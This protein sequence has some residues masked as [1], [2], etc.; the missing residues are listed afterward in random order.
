[1][2]ENI[3]EMLKKAFKNALAEAQKNET[4]DFKNIERLYHAQCS[5][6]W[7]KHLSDVLLK[8]SIQQ[9]IKKQ[10]LAFYKGNAENRQIFGLNEFLF[11]IVIAETMQF[12]T[13]SKKRN[14]QAKADKLTAIKKAT[15]IIESELQTKNSRALLVD[16][17]KLVLAKADYKMFVMSQD[18]GRTRQWAINT[19]RELI[20]EEEHSNVYLV[21]IP[22]PRDWGQE[23]T[24]SIQSLNQI[25]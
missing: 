10:Y 25:S 6:I 12:D 23:H 7:I 20:H 16:M 11:D 13:A 19:F 22:H 4:A 5:Q 3:N 9:D 2:H 17:N 14:I 8:L 1:M 18:S 15:W 24:V 21:T